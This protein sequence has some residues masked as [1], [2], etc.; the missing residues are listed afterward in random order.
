M[1]PS[2]HS[3]NLEQT[4]D[5]SF[6]FA[7][8]I[9]FSLNCGC[10]IYIG[11][12]LPFNLYTLPEVGITPAKLV[13][14]MIV[15]IFLRRIPCLLLLFRIV[16]EVRDWRQALF[17]GHFGPMGVSAIFVS[18]MAVHQLAVAQSPQTDQAQKLA[19]A[20]QPIVS[21]VVLGSI[22]IH[23]LSIPCFCLGRR[24]FDCLTRGYPTSTQRLKTLP[25]DE[26]S[27]MA[28]RP[29]IDPEK[30]GMRPDDAC[31]S[32]SRSDTR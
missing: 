18:T 17:C 11:A 12:W 23:G 28:R 7:S 1:A 29:R 15:I 22:V 31:Q 32:D 14:L 25:D 10:F 8:V 13:A 20:L 6:E 26:R 16:P 2:S 24:L 4:E 5:P 9:E 21:F 30:G 3:L 19:I 27:T